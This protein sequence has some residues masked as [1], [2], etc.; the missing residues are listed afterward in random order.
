MEKSRNAT[1]TR[2]G[3]KTRC[4]QWYILSNHWQS[5]LE[6]FEQDLH[7]L[8]HLIDNYLLWIT[9]PENLE[10][11]KAIENNLLALQRKCSALLEKVKVHRSVLAALIQK[12]DRSG[13]T[14]LGEAHAALEQE[15]ASFVK[16]Y[17]QNRLETF[18]VTEY[19]IDSEELPEIDM[20]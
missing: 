12:P 3:A 7:F 10:A 13:Q 20:P 18:K 6:F 8:H 4:E 5:D 17:R 2:D 14:E 16:H 1:D 11:V 9:L 15:L 19:I